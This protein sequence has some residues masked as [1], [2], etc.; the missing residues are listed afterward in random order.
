MVVE[1]VV[2]VGVVV[3]E[4][5]V[6]VVGVFVDEVVVVEVVEVLVVIIEVE[7]VVDATNENKFEIVNS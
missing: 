3:V 4:S 1:A 2:M 7:V 6:G 5:D